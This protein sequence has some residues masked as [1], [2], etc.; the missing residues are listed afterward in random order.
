MKK[1][2]HLLFDLDGTLWDLHTNTRLALEVLYAEF[3]FPLEKFELFFRRYHYHNDRVWA[4][5]RNGKIEKEELRWQRFH[6]AMHDVEHHTNN[7][8]LVSFAN[9]FTELCP[10]QPHLLEGALD[11]LNYCHNRYHL[12][13]LTN[14]FI[15]VQGVKMECSGLKPFFPYVIHS[16]DAGVRKPHRGFF[17][18][19]LRTVGAQPHECLMIGDDWDADILGARD[20][21][22]DQVFLTTTEDMLA[23]MAVHDSETYPRRVRH[24]YTPT[25]TINNLSSLKQLLEERNL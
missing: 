9:A 1:Y 10:R 16:E 17:D 20:L 5:Y 24:N 23:S 25:Y 13:I 19:A 21:G 4:L 14:G 12:S 2:T 8:V 3:G 22:I 6:S 11:L 7:D 15:E 18:Y